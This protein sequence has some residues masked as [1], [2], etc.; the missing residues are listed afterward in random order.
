VPGEDPKRNDTAP[1]L[2]LLFGIVWSLGINF[3]F[4]VA[5]LAVLGWLLDRWLGTGPVLA[6]VLALLG[7]TI[8]GIRFVRD[9]L[10]LNK[11]LTRDEERRRNAP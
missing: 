11:R 9:A 7:L 5:G 8:G 2:T 10:A 6:L 3:V 1:E 4:A